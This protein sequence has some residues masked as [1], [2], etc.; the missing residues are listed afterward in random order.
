MNYENF[1]LFLKTH[2]GRD[3]KLWIN[4]AWPYCCDGKQLS[5]VSSVRYL[6]LHID[7]LRLVMESAYSKCGLEIY[8]KILCLNHL[9]PLPADL[10]ARLYRVFVLPM[11]TGLFW[12]NMETA[13]CI[14]NILNV[15]QNDNFMQQYKCLG[16]YTNYHHH[17]LNSTFQISNAVDI[18][19]HTRQNL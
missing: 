14:Y 7:E 17:N 15:W 8:S 5:R 3:D 4:L 12:C 16:C 10:F 18:T 9:H 2:A 6:G 11:H 19:L 13:I 1:A